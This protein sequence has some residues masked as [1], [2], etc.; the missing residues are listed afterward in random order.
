MSTTRYK[1]SNIKGRRVGA[2]VKEM[3][4]ALGIDKIPENMV[5]HHID[6]NKH[7]NNID[8]LAVM[9][10]F[11]HNKIHSHTAW[12]KGL[13]AISNDKWRETINK[14]QSSRNNY[15]LPI[16][17]QYYDLRVSGLSVIKIAEKFNK[18]RN[19]IYSGIK[20]YEKII[21]N[22]NGDIAK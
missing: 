7:N 16:L 17:K 11:A 13:K 20:K 1:Q 18:T 19:T 10:Y 22:G 4:L 8:N 12:N 6:G 15:Y 2:H 3:C 9:N 5:V 21:N 14:V